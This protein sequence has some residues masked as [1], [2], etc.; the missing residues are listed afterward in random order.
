[1]THKEIRQRLKDFTNNSTSPLDG[2]ITMA[3]IDHIDD[4]IAQ[5][6]ITERFVYGLSIDEICHSRHYSRRWVFS[7]IDQGV[8][9][10]A[11][12]TEGVGV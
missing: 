5:K 12:N 6:I 2:E 10:I 3:L 11:R 7:K 9:E 4:P 1:M 8:K